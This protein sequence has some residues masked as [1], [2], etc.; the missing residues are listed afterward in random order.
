M[1]ITV[2]HNGIP[3]SHKSS[4]ARVCRIQPST[5]ETRGAAGGLGSDNRLLLPLLGRSLN[6]PWFCSSLLSTSESTWGPFS[7][8]S[9]CGSVRPSRASGHPS[10]QDT[11]DSRLVASVYDWTLEDA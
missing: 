3:F 9:L 8:L 5:E 11:D 6:S 4:H 10:S 2:S 7:P 1:N